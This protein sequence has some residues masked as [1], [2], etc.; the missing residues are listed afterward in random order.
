[1]QAS[2][3]R[4]ACWWNWSIQI[5]YAFVRWAMLWDRA[6]KLKVILEPAAGAWGVRGATCLGCAKETLARTKRKA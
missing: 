2:T 6:G 3:S 1:M 5:D 4:W